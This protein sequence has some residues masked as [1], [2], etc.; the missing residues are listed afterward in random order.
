MFRRRTL[1]RWTAHAVV[2]VL[3]MKAAVPLMASVAAGLQGKGVAEICD[4]YGVALPSQAHAAAPSAHAHHHHHH[5]GAA[6]DGAGGGSAP[7]PSGLHRGDHCALTALSV[8]APPDAI[9]VALAPPRA[10]A[11]AL[12]VAAT[13]GVATPDAFARWAAMLRHA[14]PLRG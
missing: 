9:A 2:F 1:A 7:A 10:P 11:A 6:D 8:F 4:V 3:L 12:P 5:G 14:P 13:G